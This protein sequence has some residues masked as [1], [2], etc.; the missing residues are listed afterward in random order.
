MT[1][2][3]QKMK[4]QSNAR[5][6]ALKILYQI[7]EK[8]A[9]SNI[10]LH[11]G[12]RNFNGKDVDRT[13]ITELVYGTVKWKITLDWV[14][15]KYSSRKVN[16]I[17][18]WIR[19]ILRMSLYQVMFLDKVPPFAACNEAVEL[20][21]IYGS[22]GTSGFVN[23]VLRTI[24][25]NLKNIVYPDIKNPE[26]Y[27]SIKYSH[28]T[29][30]VKR[31]IKNFNL[32]FSEQ[33]CKANNNIPPLTVRI[34]TLKTT[35]DHAIKLFEKEGLKVNK[36]RFLDEA[37]NI[38]NIP[39]IEGLTSYKEG[40]FQPQDEASMLVSYILAPQAG[41][42]ILDVCGAPGGK[43]THIAQLMKNEGK[44][45]VR[46]IFKHKL[47][48]VDMLAGRLGINIMEIQEHDAR[49]LDKTLI[50]RA[51]RVLVDAPCSGTGII[52][53]K[54]DIKWTRQEKDLEALVQLQKEILKV[55]SHYV[56]KGGCLVYST[57]SLEPEENEE[58]IKNFLESNGNFIIDDISPFI[59][60]DLKG[61]V[62][63]GFLRTFPHI[64]ETDGFFIARL[65]RL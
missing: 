55:S 46:D 5:E 60:A 8:G 15:N 39:S 33:L 41:Q 52:R 37:L 38:L 23:G 27:L 44:I 57:C 53:R 59:P 2:E 47:K 61:E 31:W 43:S 6:I 49:I 17:D 11:K 9:F 4:S 3:S 36:G 16:N 40:L 20:A 58:I 45:I 42:L 14:I 18:P 48:L 30:M 19:N 1:G 24:L 28:P 35:R 50:E 29:W 13:F 63:D 65:K 22:R 7:N 32:T 51:D 10:A 21:K 12:L 56:R 25:R 64:H 34:N 62:K 54:P 26:D